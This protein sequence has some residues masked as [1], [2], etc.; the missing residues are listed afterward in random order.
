M[1]FHVIKNSLLIKV[2]EFVALLDCLRDR[3]LFFFFAA[4]SHTLGPRPV[5]RLVLKDILDVNI[6]VVACFSHVVLI[7]AALG[8]YLHSQKLL[9]MHLERGGL[10]DLRILVAVVL[11]VDVLVAWVIHLSELQILMTT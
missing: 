1:S 5:V 6:A 2:E 3:V 10:I 11:K 9:T 7:I 8:S 4:V